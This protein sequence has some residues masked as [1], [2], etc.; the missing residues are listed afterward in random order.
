M[1]FQSDRRTGTAIGAAIT[2]FALLAALLLVGR[3][4]AEPVSFT[5]FTAGLVAAILFAGAGIFAYWTWGCWSLTYRMTRNAVI[6]QWAGN[7]ERI[8]LVDIV[9]IVPGRALPAPD[10]LEGV[11]WPGYHVGR[12]TVQGMPVLV[13]AAF[14]N[15]QDLLYIYTSKAVYAVA[16]G[17]QEH[18]AFEV[19]Q[20]QSLGPSTLEVH[21]NRRWLPWRLS[22]WHDQAAVALMVAALVVNLA[23]FA[24]EAFLMPA[25]P[26][27][28]ALHLTPLGTVDR[29]GPAAELLILP[30][31]GLAVLGINVVVGAVL[32]LSERFGAYLAL[33]AGV[34]TQGLLFAAALRLLS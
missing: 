4:L 20:R 33:G 1:F 26:A 15:P 32:H 7:Q 22:L 23:L 8:P 16:P 28:T 18:F 6:I 21:R 14:S 31:A 17:D 10:R 9:Q 27:E 12:G 24:Y 5:S 29:S 11:S 2:L 30:L 13:F 19:K 25:V 3:V 34:L